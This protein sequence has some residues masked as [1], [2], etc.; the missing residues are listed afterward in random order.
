MPTVEEIK[1]AIS[2]LSKEDYIHLREWFSGKDSEEWDRKIER[3]SASRKLDFLI[4]EA[5]FGEKPGTTRQT[6]DPQADESV[7]L[8]SS[9]PEKQESRPVKV[10]Q[11]R[12]VIFPAL[13]TAG[14][15]GVLFETPL[16]YW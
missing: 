12:K 6:L 14:G 8:R 5:S 13:Q 9:F 16:I 10:A 1:S 11:L 3:D 7:P 15:T 4:E 2:A